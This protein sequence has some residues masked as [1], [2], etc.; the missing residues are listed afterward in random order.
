MF[1]SAYR[2]RGYGV[3]T[4]KLLEVTR[5]WEFRVRLRSRMIFGGS[6]WGRTVLRSWKVSISKETVG[7]VSNAVRKLVLSL[8]SQFR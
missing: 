4:K 1:L 8:T 7:K 2:R 3:V 6:S 5:P